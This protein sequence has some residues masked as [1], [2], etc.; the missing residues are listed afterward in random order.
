MRTVSLKDNCFSHAYSCGNG[1][2]NILSKYINW[3]RNDINDIIFYTDNYIL[4]D[5]PHK[6]SDKISVAWIVEPKAISNHLYD[7][8]YTDWSKFDYVLSHNTNFVEE[9]NNSSKVKSLW[10]AFGGSW[11]YEQ[12]RFI[13]L[14]SKNLSIITSSKSK[15]H[16]HRM[17]HEIINSH[18]NIFDGLFGRGYNR[19]NNKIEGLR[20]Y[21]FSLVVENDNSDDFFSEKLIDC[22]VT[23]TI[24]I[25]YGTKNIGKYFDVNG[26]LLINN[27]NDFG[28]IT[29]LLNEDYYNS[30]LN[31]IKNNFALAQ[32]YVNMED[33]IYNTYKDVIFIS[34]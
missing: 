6:Y 25:Y 7:I 20:E 3:D 14:K 23:G 19:I 10:Y 27:V 33:W 28:K 32:K 12:D 21:R 13:H 22:L 2:L 8:N 16:G 17:R 1:D 26:F 31:S 9:L 34:K 5:D 4:S 29:S 30:K 11:I 15:T 24:P 18:R